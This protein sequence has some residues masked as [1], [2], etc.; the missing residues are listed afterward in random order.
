MKKLLSLGAILSMAVAV[1]SFA[2]EGSGVDLSQLTDSID[3]STVLVA[4]MAVAASLVALYAGIAGV[5]W[6]IRTVKA[7]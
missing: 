5:R 2:A 3:F 7:A 1:P 6:V 4:I